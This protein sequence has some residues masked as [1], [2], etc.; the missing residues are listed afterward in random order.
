MTTTSK[1]NI[2]QRLNAVQQEVDYIQKEKKQG[3]N[4]SIVSHDA[5]TAKVRPLMVKHGVLYYPE[6]MRL[7]QNGN[8]T[9]VMLDIRFV[10]IDSPA[11]HIIVATAGYGIDTQD[12]GIGKAISYAVKYALLKALG[13]ETGDEPDLDQNAKH[14]PEPPR[15]GLTEGTQ[16]ASKAGSREIYDTLV[17]G[18]RNAPTVSALTAW[19]KN[20]TAEIDKLPA[21]WVDEL[22][23][24][25]MDRKSELTRNLAA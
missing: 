11:D 15:L 6:N 1:P 3:M 22:R 14:E 7:T 19:Q 13:L 12:K 21:D 4:Y 16:G 20:N 2:L 17:K 23:V 25:F 10:S 9:E 5:V 24:E 8:R 18:I